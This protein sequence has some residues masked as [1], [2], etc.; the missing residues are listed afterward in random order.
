ML[1]FMSLRCFPTRGC[2]WVSPQKKL[3]EDFRE[4]RAT[5]EK[6][7][8]LQPNHVFFILCLCHIL[9]LDVAAWLIIWY[10]GASLVPFL[11][12][13]VLLGTVQVSNYTK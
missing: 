12:S 2:F 13:A 8:L 6:M 9:V 10:Y 5:V 11:F 3:V 4:L 1:L 7:G